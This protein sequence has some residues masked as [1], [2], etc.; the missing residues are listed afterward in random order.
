MERK[1]NRED[2]A[3]V[4][5]LDMIGDYENSTPSVLG[6]VMEHEVKENILHKENP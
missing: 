2:L 4:K 6:S 1:W 5:E 3:W